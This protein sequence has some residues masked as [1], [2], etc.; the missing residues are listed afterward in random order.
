[1]T[2]FP[3]HLTLYARRKTPPSGERRGHTAPGQ[4]VHS[5]QTPEEKTYWAS[6]SDGVN[7]ESVTVL[8]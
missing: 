8:V 7:A 2:N 5:A 4:H 3:F 1:M 6:L